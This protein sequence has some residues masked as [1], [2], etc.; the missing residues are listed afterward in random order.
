MLVE[1]SHRDIWFVGERGLFHLNR[2][3]GTDYSP[4]CNRNGLSAESVYA[5]EAGEFVDAG[6]FPDLG[7]VKYDPTGGALDEIPASRPRCR[8]PGIHDER[9]LG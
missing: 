4:S 2:Q 9:G 8:R 5:D 6:Q 3:T 1:G 7:L